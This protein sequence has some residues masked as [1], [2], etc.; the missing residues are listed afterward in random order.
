MT[1]PDL[2][3]E[4]S[5]LRDLFHRRLLEDRS[6]NDLIVALHESLRT[7]DA[8]S[9]GEAFRDLFRELLIAVDRL[10]T[11]EP[12]REL[13]DSV[14]DEVRE[15]MARRGLAPVPTS[16]H[17]DAR[18]H[19]AAEAIDAGPGRVAGEIVDVVRHGYLLGERLLRPAKVVV[20]RASA[21]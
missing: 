1:T 19:E 4:I 17:F 11:E 16:T 20:V 9:T 8:L 3:Q 12:S 15:A 13:C 7:R 14:A 21:S 18:Y 2:A 6:K 5:S 10:V